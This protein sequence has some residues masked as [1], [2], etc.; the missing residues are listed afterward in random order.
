MGVLEYF[1][2][3]FTMLYEL[4]GLLVILGVSAHLSKRMKKL[5]VTVVILLFLESVIFSRKL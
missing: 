1:L 5:S 3:N 4:V 2:D